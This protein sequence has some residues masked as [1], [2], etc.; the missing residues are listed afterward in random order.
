MDLIKNGAKLDYE[1]K[2]VTNDGLV[3]VPYIFSGHPANVFLK[4][5]VNERLDRNELGALF[6]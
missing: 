6:K 2:L 3:S 5:L 4:C 1:K